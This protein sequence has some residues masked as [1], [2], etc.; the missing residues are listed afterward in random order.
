MRDAGVADDE[1][2]PAADPRLRP[3]RAHRLN[4][5]GGGLRRPQTTLVSPCR[6]CDE[7]RRLERF[8]V[9]SAP[10]DARLKPQG[11]AHNARKRRVRGLLTIARRS[12]NKRSVG[13]SPLPARKECAKKRIEGRLT[14]WLGTDSGGEGSARALQ[15]TQRRLF[16]ARDH[17]RRARSPPVA[18]RT[19]H[20]DRAGGLEG[21]GRSTTPT[22]LHGARAPAGARRRGRKAA[23]GPESDRRRLRTLYGDAPSA[24]Q[25]P[26]G[27]SL[28]PRWQATAS[29]RL[30]SSRHRGR[31]SSRRSGTPR[32]GH[33]GGGE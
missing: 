31:K 2:P 14:V 10:R 1:R 29:S 3:A 18:R 27:G 32:T 23:S 26:G 24:A 17:R 33:L 13:R 12:R 25:P 7:G 16:E 20:T 21:S 4:R 22:C 30:G 28:P 11:W 6:D 19:A 5:R 8:P 9:V 15:E